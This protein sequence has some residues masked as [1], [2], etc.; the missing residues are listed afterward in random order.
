[1]IYNV[2]PGAFQSGGKRMQV[3]GWT[4]RREATGAD[5]NS[6]QSEAA[7]K[8]EEKG[9]RCGYILA[10]LIC[11]MGKARDESDILFISQE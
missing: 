9:G 2:G 11:E 3:Q 6:F 1:M 10:C 5:A 4:F 7:T 8:E